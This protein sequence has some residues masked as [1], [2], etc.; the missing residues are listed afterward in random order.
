VRDTGI[1][2]STSQQNKLFNAFSQLDPSF[3]RRHTGTGLGL[4]ISKRLTDLMGGTI[5]VESRAGQGTSFR[6]ALPL[7][8]SGEAVDLGATFAGFG[9]LDVLVST[10]DPVLARAVSNILDNAAAR[11]ILVQDAVALK[12]ALEADCKHGTTRALI[13][14]ADLDGAEL[15]KVLDILQGLETAETLAVVVL[16]PYQS[17]SFGEGL[18]GGCFKLQHLAKPPRSAGLI[19]AL[20][21]EPQQSQERDRAGPGRERSLSSRAAVALERGQAE[22]PSS[23]RGGNGSTRVLLADDNSVNR[24][25]AAIFLKQLGLLLDEVENGEEAV[26]ACR[27]TA[28]DLVLMDV[29]MPVMDGIEATRQIRALDN[30]CNTRIPIV[31]L[32]ADAMHEERE[33]FLRSGMDDHIAK[34]ITLQALRSLIEH[35][36]GR[37]VAHG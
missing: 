14:D 29:H 12:A 11:P 32:T 37:E 3:T 7:A 21:G 15:D 4:A 26:E 23:L 5:A 10:Q 36:D 1:G 22:P 27:S 30:N 34:P 19:K 31:A 35:W 2:I 8:E 13:I 16:E 33:R 24:R 28:Y 9:D 25:L 18:Q 6:L 20:R 17:P